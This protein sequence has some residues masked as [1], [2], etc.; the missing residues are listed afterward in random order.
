MLMMIF[1]YL[2]EFT[3]VT[4]R[5]DIGRVETSQP[6]VANLLREACTAQTREMICMEIQL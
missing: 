2:I 3:V 4:V 6:S 1:R 5:V